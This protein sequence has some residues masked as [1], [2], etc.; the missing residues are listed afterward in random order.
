MTSFV[1]GLTYMC[2]RV[3]GVKRFQPSLVTSLLFFAEKT[4]NSSIDVL[5]CQGGGVETERVIKFTR[6]FGH[7]PVTPAQWQDLPAD[8]APGQVDTS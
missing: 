5:L 6:E 7:K 1:K 8:P 4:L 3:L 2:S